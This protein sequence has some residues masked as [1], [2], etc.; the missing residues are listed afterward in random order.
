MSKQEAEQRGAA[1]LFALN[2]LEL[3]LLGAVEQAVITVACGR[4]YEQG[5]RS[6]LNKEEA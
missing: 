1:V 5:T 6:L 3:G 4:A 2:R